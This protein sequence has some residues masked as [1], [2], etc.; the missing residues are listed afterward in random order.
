[1][2]Q[3]YE[4]QEA[5]ARRPCRKMLRDRVAEVAIPSKVLA[6]GWNQVASPDSREK[7]GG[8]GEALLVEAYRCLR[9][10]TP[11]FLNLGHT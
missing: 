3:S 1:M 5:T 9:S 2:P 7:G 4:D 6:C 11:L 10:K 8:G